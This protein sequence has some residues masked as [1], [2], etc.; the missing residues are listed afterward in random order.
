MINMYI[1]KTNKRFLLAVSVA[2]VLL[3]A[4]AV[5]VFALPA[6]EEGTPYIDKDGKRQLRNDVTEITG[7]GDITDNELTSGWYIVKGTFTLSNTLKIT[8]D[9]HLILDDGCD[10]TV[11]GTAN[12]AGINVTGANSLSIYAVTADEGTT[13]KITAAGGTVGAYSGAAGIGG[14]YREDCGNVTIN[15]GKVDAT[16]SASSGSYSGGAG[17]GGGYGGTGGTITINGGFVTSTSIKG[18]A[19]IG[20]GTSRNGGIIAITNGTINATGHGGAG[21]GGGYGAGGDGGN[22]S[23]TGG[24]ITAIGQY[25]GAGIGGG[26]A[27]GL[28]DTIV[29][30]GGNITAIADGEY[31]GG[32]GIG[33]GE[34]QGINN[35]HY[36]LIYG[37]NTIVTVKGAAGSQ[38]IGGG[39]GS[40]GVTWARYKAFVA[41]PHGNL[42]APD[43]TLLGNAVKFTA[44][45][46]TATGAVTTVLPSDRFGENAV[47]LTGLDQTGKMMSVLTTFWTT[48]QMSF[49][50]EGYDNSPITVTGA[51]LTT[52]GITVAFEGLALSYGISLDRSGTYSFDNAA[53]GYPAQTP[54]TVIVAN[55]GSAP[56][57]SL[58]I[59]L[60]GTGASSFTVSP[61]STG[62]IA[63]SGNTTF[64]VVPKSGLTVGTYTATV[65]V[66][67]ASGNTNPVPPE[68]FNVSFTVEKADTTTTLSSDKSPSPYGTPVAFTAVV[69]SSGSTPYGIVEF[70]DG[71]VRIGTV[72]LDASGTAV[73]STSALTVGTHPIT[74]RYLGGDDFNASQSAILNLSVYKES[75]DIY[76]ITSTAQPG[77][78]IT[79]P[80]TVAVNG[81]SSR[82]FTFSANPGYSVNAVVV[83]GI[84]LSQEDVA[85]GTYT[86]SNVRANHTIAVKVNDVLTIAVVEGKGYAEYSIDDS[87]FLLYTSAVSLPHLC[88]LK[89]R[90]FA[91][92]GY[93]FKEWNN[94]G[95]HMAD[96]E[97]SFKGI[98]TNLHLE[99][100]FTEEKS[101]FDMDGLLLWIFVIIAL[102]ILVGFLFW[103]FYRR[104]RLDV[105]KVQSSIIG[106]DKVRRKKAYRFKIEGEQKGD[107]SYSVGEE[108]EWKTL[109]PNSDGEYVIP[110][111]EVIGTLTI[112]H[113]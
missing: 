33:G 101:S 108:G 35:G 18:A 96:E 40:N 87:P 97:I 25:G 39:T 111:E 7:P 11:N 26:G 99:L 55:T 12:G 10:V 44:D 2:S 113:R 52:P 65:T 77:T 106:K 4:A 80:G 43:G 107:V 13:G 62:S 75:G 29:I 89:V 110:K 103:L 51:N 104:G 50:L 59:A 64:I 86:F 34:S 61:A 38:D 54:L 79:P 78:T 56:T 14:G 57:G 6:A 5:I 72:L 94:D 74:A 82:T 60:S 9:V 45:P 112:D 63:V 68:T 19:A 32:A 67:P 20:G 73:F 95:L 90:A 47:I 24:T 84:P 76:Y 28:A 70:Y 46:S 37:D 49:A 53:M 109:S 58:A 105:I 31:W 92:E 30:S 23:I 36:V 8:G 91:D 100:Y 1:G 69:T 98:I 85:K 17:I 41:L 16:G 88:D 48:T 83:D 27:G 21:I 22:I 66:S 42:K 81:G 3:V 93:K 71:D 15:G 102:A